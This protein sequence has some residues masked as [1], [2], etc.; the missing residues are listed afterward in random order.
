LPKTEAIS[1]DPKS[2]Y[3]ISKLTAEQYCHLFNDAFGQ[4]TV[5]LRYFNIF[6]PRQD[7]SS[8]YSGVIS[9]FVDK[10]AQ[11]IAPLIYGDGEQTRDFV[12]VEDVVRANLLAAHVPEAAGQIFNICTGHQVSINQLFRALQRIFACDLEPIYQPGRPGDIRYSY[13]SPAQAQK[14]LDWSAGVTFETGLRRL[15]ESMGGSLL[16]QTFGTGEK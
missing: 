10:L 3:G 13:G 7:P 5:I 4:E 12:F 11:G 15:V 16:R 8:P 6:G 2:P 14:I 1:L 9:I